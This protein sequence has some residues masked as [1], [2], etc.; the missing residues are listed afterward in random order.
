MI[1]MDFT[2]KELRRALGPR[3]KACGL[4]GAV[5]KA[6]RRV[7]GEAFVRSTEID[8]RKKTFSVDQTLSF[9]TNMTSFQHVS[10]H[11]SLPLCAAC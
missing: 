2:N 11:S 4:R 5:M 7:C 8:P 3:K 10:A 9:P 1:D 6:S